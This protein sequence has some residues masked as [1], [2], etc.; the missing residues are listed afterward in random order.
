MEPDFPVGTT[1]NNPFVYQSKTEPRLANSKK[2][3]EGPDNK[4]VQTRIDHDVVSRYDLMTL[5]TDEVAHVLQ[6]H[7]QRVLELAQ[8]GQLPGAKI[9][10]GWIF[11]PTDVAEFLQKQ[12]IEQTAQRAKNM[13]PVLEGK[14]SQTYHSPGRKRNELPLCVRL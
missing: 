7:E 10:R 4:R 6:C 2:E 9:G 14:S 1:L 11:R 12:V 13:T 8:Q 5:S 3:N